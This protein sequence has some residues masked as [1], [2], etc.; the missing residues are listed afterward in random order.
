MIGPHCHATLLPSSN[1]KSPSPSAFSSYTN[2]TNPTSTN[3]EGGEEEEGDEP[4]G[5][6]GM[7]NMPN[8][9]NF[10]KPHPHS[11]SP[12]SNTATTMTTNT[13]S[14]K[15]SPSPA[16]SSSHNHRR[17]SHPRNGSI[18]YGNVFDS[19]PP[20]YHP[21]SNS[22]TFKTNPQP[23]MNSMN[24]SMKSFHCSTNSIGQNGHNPSVE[25]LNTF[26]NGG[27]MGMGGC[28]YGNGNGSNGS[29]GGG[30]LDRR[31]TRN[32]HHH[33]FNTN[34]RMDLQGIRQNFGSP[35]R[36]R[37]GGGEEN[38]MS[39]SF[40]RLSNNNNNNNNNNNGVGVMGLEY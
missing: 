10:H 16:I 4:N 5:L 17:E 34:Q 27:A 39:R 3:N 30:T 24:P 28:S 7:G 6:M 1:R 33:Q 15:G 23:L 36:R 29:N 40:T 37:G 9:L 21:T 32:G 8:G 18:L 35:T 14:S 31:K 11:H 19:K 20:V 26:G 12:D 22:S 13:N 25:Y 38:V 2:N